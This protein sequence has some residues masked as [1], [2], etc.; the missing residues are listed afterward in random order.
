MAARFKRRDGAA[1]ATSDSGE[2]LRARLGRT[3]ERTA[4]GSSP[5]AG[6]DDTG[7]GPGAVERGKLRRRLRRLRRTREVLLLEVGALVFELRRRGRKDDALVERKVAELKVIDDETRAIAKALATD[8]TLTELVQSGIAGTC[9]QCGAIHSIDARFC[10][11]CG[12]PV[13]AAAHSQGGA[14]GAGTGDGPQ[15]RQATQTAGAGSPGSP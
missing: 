1:S 15:A 8:G 7:R 9:E 3:V 5:P 12:A 2:G 11:S 4:A 13:S 14:D 10:S 6:A